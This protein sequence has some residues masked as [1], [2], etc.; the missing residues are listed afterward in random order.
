MRMRA[1]RAKVAAL[2]EMDTTSVQMRG[3]ER[4]RLFERASAWR[5]NE[6]GVK[7]SEFLRLQRT[8]K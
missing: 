2:H 6:R 5:V 4:A 8:A 7:C 3:G 1:S